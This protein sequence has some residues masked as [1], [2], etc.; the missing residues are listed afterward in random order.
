MA[1]KELKRSG[2]PI[3]LGTTETL[4][5]IGAMGVASSTQCEQIRQGMPQ[6][7]TFH[8][9][10]LGAADRSRLFLLRPQGLAEWWNFH[11]W[12]HSADVAFWVSRN[13]EFRTRHLESCGELRKGKC[14]CS[15]TALVW[16]IGSHLLFSRQAGSL[17]TID[18]I[19]RTLIWSG[20][21]AKN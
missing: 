16:S 2:N 1:R 20:F 18:A 11:D 19:T 8:R 21:Q 7:G 5:I 3:Q 4:P 9:Y 10:L 14:P 15:N 17:G 6:P 12:P 13:Y